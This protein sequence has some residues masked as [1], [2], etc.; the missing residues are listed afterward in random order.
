LFQFRPLLELFEQ[1]SKDA[2]SEAVAVLNRCKALARTI[3][4]QRYPGIT[5]KFGTNIPSKAVADKLVDGYLRTLETVFRVLHFP[6][7]MRDYEKFWEAPDAVGVPFTIQLQL[8]MAIGATLYDETF[9]MRKSAVQWVTEAQYWLLGPPAK[10]KLTITGLQIMIL[11]TLARETASVGGDLAWIHVG[12]LLRS[13]LY[14][15]LHRDPSRLPRMSRLDAEMRR[16]LW[17]TIMEIELKSSIDSG[18][19]PMIAL[20]MSDTRAPA[21]VD[22]VDLMDDDTAVDDGDEDRFTDM[23][24]AL[25]MRDSFRERLAIYQ[26]LNATPFKGTYDDTIRLHRRFMAAFTTLTSKL[27]GYPSS[28]RRP[29]AFQC[30]SVEVMARRCLMNLHLPYLGPG[31][32]EPAFAFSRA[33]V[34]EASA[35]IYY[36]IFPAA[37]HDPAGPLLPPEGPSEILS[38]EGDDLARFALCGAGFWRL[39]ATQ[40]SMVAALELQMVAQ[41]DQGLGPPLFRP[42]LLNILRHS[43]PYYLS[44]IEA[45]ETN[46][47][48]YLFITALAGHVQAA[49][50]GRTGQQLLE[51]ILTAAIRTEKLCFEILKRQ[52]GSAGLEDAT[53]SEPSDD[54]FNWDS[55]ITV[56]GGWGDAAV[57]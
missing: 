23:T 52:A 41:E 49:M 51:P 56:D 42:D 13:A 18:G 6:T 39:L 50:D 17:N 2:K 1:Q 3:K 34:T 4:A 30:R 28:R 35:K 36:L 7:F 37:A 10:G 8:V 16:R 14:M 22:D 40:P 44:R 33:Q 55:L 5:T 25:L 45:G 26:M 19:Y 31:F 9:T 15:G 29:T 32:R 43:L 48:G 20:D 21:D 11:L 38:T 27:K 57:S 54:P 47:K 46:V 24:V 53:A 12:S